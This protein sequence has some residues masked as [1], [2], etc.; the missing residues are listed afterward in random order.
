MNHA[1]APGYISLEDAALA[2]GMSRDQLN[3]RLVKYH[4]ARYRDPLDRRA[5]M[6]ERADLEAF[7][8][9]QRVAAPRQAVAT[10]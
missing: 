3:R 5:R 6:I 1:I 2:T 7:L 10:T 9:P 8:T 4:V